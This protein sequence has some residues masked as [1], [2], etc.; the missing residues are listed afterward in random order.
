MKI[1]SKIIWGG[2]SKAQVLLIREKNQTSIISC[3]CPFKVQSLIPLLQYLIYRIVMA[4][5]FVGGIFWHALHTRFN[6]PTHLLQNKYSR[7]YPIKKSLDTVST[8]NCQHQLFLVYCRDTLGAK[9]LIY[10]T[11]QVNSNLLS[12]SCQLYLFHLYL[13][14]QRVFKHFASFFYQCTQLHTYF[15][16]LNLSYLINAATLLSYVFY[17]CT[18]FGLLALFCINL[19]AVASGIFLNS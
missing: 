3:Q 16:L 12:I 18:Y 5:F 1:F 14:Q 4:A 11:N 7:A 10:M 17:Q 2:Y 15:N 6:I 8:C 9:W 13:S 19:A